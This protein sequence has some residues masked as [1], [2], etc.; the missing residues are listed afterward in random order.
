MNNITKPRILW[1][2]LLRALAAI[3]VVVVH[4]IPSNT[5]EL[6]L[7]LRTIIS[8]IMIPLFFAISG[9]LFNIKD[10]NPINLFK[11]LLNGLIV[12][13][14]FLSFIWLKVVLI[15]SRGI[16]FFSKELYDF[17]SGK[18]Y[19][20]INACFIAEIVFFFTRKYAK[21]VRSTCIVSLT[22]LAI[23]LVLA[24]LNIGNFSMFNRA[25]IA[26]AYM[27]LGFLIKTHEESLSKVKWRAI[28][29]PSA[30]YIVLIIF[31]AIQWPTQPMDIHT[32]RYPHL[33]YCLLTIFIGI[34]TL[35]LIARKIKKI[36]SIIVFIGQN[37]LYFYVLQFR[38]FA[39]CNKAFSL[40]G[41][42]N[43]N[44]LPLQILKI[45]AAIIGCSIIAFI[46]N[47]LF[48]QFVGKKR[49]LKC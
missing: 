14:V 41:I 31:G 16:S 32:N 23:G 43:V 44:T 17:V 45:C 11:R 42:R 46:F 20:Y 28:L 8:P 33:P 38:M 25:L 49:L 9:Y 2:D 48:P 26:Q 3:F 19:W 40:I 12:P 47:K 7:I 6:A 10:G 27:M 36:P 1:I 34:I 13:T 37:S 24:K 29:I 21:T 18:S 15:P 5:G 4:A 35:F 22:Y 30:F 39:I